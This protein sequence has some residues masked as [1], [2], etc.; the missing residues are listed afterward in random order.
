[1]DSR[2]LVR[3][4]L[5]VLISK[6]PFF[7]RSWLPWRSTTGQRAHTKRLQIAQPWMGPMCNNFASC[8]LI[9]F[10][11]RTL[12]EVYMGISCPSNSAETEEEMQGFI[13]SWFTPPRL[14]LQWFCWLAKPTV[15]SFPVSTPGALETWRRCPSRTV[16]HKNMGEVSASSSPLIHPQ[17]P[18]AW[19]QGLLRWH[20]P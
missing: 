3:A 2:W 4:H 13:Q 7:S 1:M 6:A 20:S 12:L 8:P 9:K 19:I 15:Q 11:I 5:L 17:K 16:R 14:S 18:Q 10:K